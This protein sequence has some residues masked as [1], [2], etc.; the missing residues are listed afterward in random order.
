MSREESAFSVKLA[1]GHRLTEGLGGQSYG[2]Q[3][4]GFPICYADD[5]TATVLGTLPNGKPGLVVKEEKGWTSVFSSVPMLPT[6]LMRNIAQLAGAHTYI[7]TE[8]VVWASKSLVA[9]C[10][11]DAGKRT[12]TLPKKANVRDL[13]T[14]VVVG[15]GVSSFEADFADHAT[16]VFV[17]E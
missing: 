12:V 17:V 16:R 1:E 14:D 11:K 2:D 7:G 3:H 5:A 10:V 13:Y 8:D 4:R 6:R 15:R 9:V